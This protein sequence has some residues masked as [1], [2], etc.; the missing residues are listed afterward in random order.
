MP[1]NELENLTRSIVEGLSAQAIRF[2]NSSIAALPGNTS[3]V[4]ERAA[5]ERPAAADEIER[6]L[7]PIRPQSVLPREGAADA[8]RLAAEIEQL[9]RVVA[10]PTSTT[11]FGASS[12]S[13][14]S[15][16]NSGGSTAE[17]V[18]KTLGMV[19]G[20]GPLATGL[21]AIFGS[22]SNV[23]AIPAMQ[24]QPP[25]PL[26]LEAGLTPDGQFTQISYGAN[27]VSRPA[28]SSSGRVS[29][30]AAPIQ[31]N[32]Q[33]MDSRSFLDHSDDIARAV[34]EAMLHSHA[35]NDVV[36]EL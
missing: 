18:I 1:T 9:R 17:T 12:A 29:A 31:I 10:E 4:P 5:S 32:V 11:Q 23:E 20:L 6:L 7:L 16:E 25:A 8:G 30:A 2:E 27:G 15:E 21:M 19:T 26:A 13:R 36:S 33:A 22:R 14:T 28:A 35:L 24:F 34:R 3:G